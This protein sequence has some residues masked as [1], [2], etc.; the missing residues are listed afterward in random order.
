LTL[1]RAR[2]AVYTCPAKG[3]DGDEYAGGAEQRVRSGG[4]GRGSA[5]RKSLL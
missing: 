5:G 1:T 4:S 3:H 2:R